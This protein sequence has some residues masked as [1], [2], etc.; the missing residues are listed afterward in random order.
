[1]NAK[2]RNRTLYWS[3]AAD[4]ADRVLYVLLAAWIVAAAIT[5]SEPGYWPAVGIVCLG[6]VR[7]RMIARAIRVDAILR[8]SE[9]EARRENRAIS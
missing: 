8:E 3:D 5:L 7:I 9:E 4:L 6:L 1:M 2:Q